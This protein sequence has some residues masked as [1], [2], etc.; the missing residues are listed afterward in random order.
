MFLC[1]LQ[2]QKKQT[3]SLILSRNIMCQQNPDNPVHYSIKSGLNKHFKAEHRQPVADADV[4][5]LEKCLN[6]IMDYNSS[7]VRC[8]ILR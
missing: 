5:N 4:E 7:T 2:S 3:N 6:L 8:H 1:N